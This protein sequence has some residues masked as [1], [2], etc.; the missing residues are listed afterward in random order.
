MQ[1]CCLA[2][3][4]RYPKD[5]ARR[6]HTNKFHLP[7]LVSPAEVRKWGG[8]GV[9]CVSELHDTSNR[10][11]RHNPKTHTGRRRGHPTRTLSQTVAMCPA[12]DFVWSVQI[13]WYGVRGDPALSKATLTHMPDILNARSPQFMYQERHA[14]SY[15]SPKPKYLE[16]L[17]DPNASCQYHGIS[18]PRFAPNGA[19][20]GS[21]GSCSRTVS[22]RRLLSTWADHI[23]ASTAP[24]RSDADKKMQMIMRQ[25]DSE[26]PPTW[27]ARGGDAS[28][29]SERHTPA[30]KS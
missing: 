6:A 26:R 30:F 1:S 12:V 13:L 19:R 10:Y 11:L 5:V 21:L 23:S 4:V 7:P 17:F 8:G 18:P 16:Y 25:C 14:W 2:E 15:T 20:A 24:R 9:R 29:V 27:G 28:N 22:G 3:R